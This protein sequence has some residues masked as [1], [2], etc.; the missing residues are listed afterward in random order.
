[1][2]KEAFLICA[3]AVPAFNFP[4]VKLMEG[5]YIQKEEEQLKDWLRKNNPD[6]E[7]FIHPN[8][9]EEKLKEYGWER[10]PFVYNDKQIWIRRKPAH[11][12]S[13]KTS[14]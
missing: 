6:A 4:H 10:V 12:K 13:P 5:N 1:M 11:D 3:L 9:Q 8:P 14:A 7:I 2:V